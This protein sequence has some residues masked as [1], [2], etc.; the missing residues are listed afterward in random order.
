M[1]KNLILTFALLQQSAPCSYVS[2][3]TKFLQIN[4]FDI[5]AAFIKHRHTLLL[6][7]M[8]H[9]R[10]SEKGEHC[11]CFPASDVVVDDNLDVPG[12][13]DDGTG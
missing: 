13:L 9:A 4:S 5:M 2:V 12:R 7:L 8:K 11:L 1:L 3:C 10:Y 6:K